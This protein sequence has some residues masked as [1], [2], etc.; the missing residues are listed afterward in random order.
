MTILRPS[1]APAALRGLPAGV[2]LLAD[3]RIGGIIVG[4]HQ[5]LHVEH[6]PDLAPC[7]RG[8][9][10]LREPGV[11]TATAYTP[12]HDWEAWLGLEFAVHLSG[13][14]HA[15]AIP[16]VPC[17]TSPPVPNW[18]LTGQCASRTWPES[19][20]RTLRSPTW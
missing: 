18:Y 5:G 9:E 16:A 10:A 20:A 11:A 7:R 13:Y 17:L 19:K 15:H 6:L 2:I 4:E 3:R 1:P 8:L 12:D 14:R